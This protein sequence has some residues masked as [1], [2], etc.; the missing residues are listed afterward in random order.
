M[1][2]T[3]QPLL[4]IDAA[5]PVEEKVA[6]LQH[7]LGEHY[8]HESGV[9]YALWHWEGDDL[10]PFR[11]EDFAGQSSIS[12]PEGLT[13]EGWG[14]QENSSWTSGLFLWSQAL[15]YQATGEEEALAYARKAFRSLD[16]IFGLAEADGQR[17]FL[18][19]PY[20]LRLSRQTSPD[21]YIAAALGMW[22]FRPF[23]DRATRQRIDD[24]LPA[25]ADWWRERD[26]T[27][28]YFTRHWP[29]LEVGY[30]YP[31]MACLHYLA[32]LT[33]GAARYL[34]ECRRLIGLAGSWPTRFDA[35]RALMIER[36]ATDW[37]TYL[38]GAEYDPERRPYL[39]ASTE[40]R[41]AM[42]M[43]VVSA[44]CFL[45][46][47]LALGQTLKQALGRYHRYMQFGLR[48]DLLSLYSIQL[49]LERDSWFPLRSLPTAES[50]AAA[51]G[52]SLFA[53]Y[54]SEVCWGD[55]ASRIVDVSVIGY[56]Y[57]R[58]FC[59]G[60]LALARA[61]LARLDN[62]R[63]HWIIDPDGEQLLPG[64]RWMS[65]VLSSDVPAFTLLAYWRAR[66]Y[67]VPLIQGR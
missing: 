14:N 42:W 33:S 54:H 29:I 31:T 41:A 38:H 53:A 50:K 30:H 49:D 8:F 52:G 12:A 40:R 26:Y 55:A 1:T 34:D 45:R 58:E 18:C 46:H 51:L 36:G 64:V 20:D 9:M 66:A 3:G 57:A 16:L 56:Q 28:Q 10:R 67:G 27:L 24:L 7:F 13:P 37:P 65:Q 32:Y 47:D 19:K 48:P 23:A 4:A 63:L 61:L 15:R 5:L 62:R 11:R 21:Q 6:R 22:A 60:A 35:D 59:P 44:E 17:G 43:M 39:M 25:M 2:A